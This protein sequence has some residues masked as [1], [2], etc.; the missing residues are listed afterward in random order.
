MCELLAADVTSVI[1]IK[2]KT[3][4]FEGNAGDDV[5][6]FFSVSFIF[7]SRLKSRPKQGYEKHDL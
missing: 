4:I 2:V 7:L 6:L 3:A 5:I 1:A